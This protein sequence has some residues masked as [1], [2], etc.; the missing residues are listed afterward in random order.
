MPCEP[1]RY[2]SLPTNFSKL[3]ANIKLN[4]VLVVT[5]LRMQALYLVGS[6]DVTYS[7][8]YLGFLSMFGAF[9]SIITCCIPLALPGFKRVLEWM[10]F[11]RIRLR[12]RRR[13][14]RTFS[15]VD[16]R[17]TRV[18]GYLSNFMSTRPT[19][20]PGHTVY[21]IQN[22]HQSLPEP[23]RG[24]RD[25]HRS[26]LVTYYIR[27]RRMQDGAIASQGSGT[28]S[29]LSLINGSQNSLESRATS[30]E[31][32]SQGSVRIYYMR[33]QDPDH[34]G[35]EEQPRSISGLLQDDLTPD[36]RYSFDLQ[37][38]NHDTPEVKPLLRRMTWNGRDSI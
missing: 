19:D 4:R 29:Q 23:S 21:H 30:S 1:Q 3:I 9:L 16:S 34:I 8:G 31:Q 13:W 27:S 15:Y 28:M 5:G 14:P 32:T 37:W 7:K 25:P 33:P 18:F 38:Q 2:T 12:L 17:L 22:S 10:G 11:S 26:S 35:V 24:S 6:P 36:R 20:A